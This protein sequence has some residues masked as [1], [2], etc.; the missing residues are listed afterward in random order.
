MNA[1]ILYDDFALALKA[2]AML[3]R[4]A[5]H[6]AEA[7]LWS[8]KPWRANLLTLTGLANAALSDAAEA[9]LVV[10]AVRQTEAIPT[11]VLVWLERWAACRQVQDAAL[12]VF[13]GGHGG[14]L[15]TTTSPEL[16]RFA[17]RHGLSF[18]FDDGTPA[19]DESASS[20]DN[21]RERERSQ[22]TTM[23]Q[24][25]EQPIH[26]YYQHWGINE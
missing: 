4:A 17:E 8:V 23:I 5:Q 26:S 19:Q 3:E 12:A 20:L 24:I 15:S 2:K 10:L 7:T 22:T 9:Q 11:W 18:I 21:L 25:L 13:D 1:V 14:T 6:A 16:S